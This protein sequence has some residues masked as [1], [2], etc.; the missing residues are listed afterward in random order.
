MFVS[1]VK[2]SDT[3]RLLVLVGNQL[4]FTL[5]DSGSNY[6]FV[7]ENF[8]PRTALNC[9]L[10]LTVKVTVANGQLMQSQKLVPALSWLHIPNY[11]ACTAARSV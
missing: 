6:T 8:A 2:T 10:A 11:Y 1:G 4:M 5:V 3:V 9:V 7:D